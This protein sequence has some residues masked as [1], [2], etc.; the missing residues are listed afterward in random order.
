M[1]QDVIL[2][3]SFIVLDMRGDLVNAALQ[4]CAG[5][6]AP[7]KVKLFD[8]RERERPLGFNPLFGAGES[9]FR[10]LNV[11]DAITKESESFGVQLAETLRLSLLLLAEANAPITRLEDLLTNEVY[12]AELLTKSNSDS[13]TQ[14]WERYNSLSN[15]KQAAY[16]SPVMNK[17]SMLFATEGL[18]RMFGHQAPVDLGKH[19]NTPGTVT[20]ISLAVDELH[21]AG[22]MTGAL[23][24]SSILR[25][26]FGRV[27]I[28]EA[29][30]VPVRMYV[31]EFESFNMDDFES[32]LAEGRRFRLSIVLAHQVL[33]QLSTKVR[34]MILN[35]VG[36][37]LVFR[38]GREDSQVL[39]KD[40]TGDPKAFDLASFP[41]GDAVLWT[42][43]REPLHI[44]INEPLFA[45]GEL[46]AKT[47]QFIRELR[48]L[49][50]PFEEVSRAS[51]P[52]KESRTKPSQASNLEE[53]L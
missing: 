38:T 35:N 19:L 34:S 51:K 4:L 37:K 23:F 50:P 41:P 5:R 14:F 53:W 36:V 30:R 47:K 16:V 17:V 39:S 6:V 26:I 44:E 42:R 25:E 24:L 10:A 27:S 2:G 43:T 31:D 7:E 22:K 11:L 1:N 18:R 21:A 12:R 13:S 46:S 48:K 3:Q 29:S 32:V 40:L 15:E 33:S 28:P 49:A 9:Y 20:L 45:V 8:L 52:E